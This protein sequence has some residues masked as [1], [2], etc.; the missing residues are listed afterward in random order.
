MIATTGADMLGITTGTLGA[1]NDTVEFLVDDA[2]YF[3]VQ[4]VG[5]L[6]GTTSFEA[7]INGTN[8]VALSL[9]STAGTA[10]TTGAISTTSNGIFYVEPF[11]NKI[12]VKATAYTSGT[13]TVTGFAR[14]I[15][16]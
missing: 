3:A 12:R 14:R 11:F 6:I 7:T 10:K 4:L 16:K 15:S 5:S 1:L 2:D 13:T 9:I 8:W